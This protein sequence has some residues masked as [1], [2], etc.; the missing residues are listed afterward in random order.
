MAGLGRVLLSQRVSEGVQRHWEPAEGLYR[1]LQPS[2]CST[3]LTEKLEHTHSHSGF[4][5][6]K[7]N[8]AKCFN[9]ASIILNI[10]MCMHSKHTANYITILYFHLNLKY[11]PLISLSLPSFFSALLFQV[12][13][14][15]NSGSA[16]TPT[17]RYSPST[18]LGNT[19]THTH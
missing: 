8:L 10:L 2:P 19:H 4:L 3:H 6:A 9:N 11:V 16:S 15:T 14:T 7:S 18:G 13:C 17:I 5:R 12:T 1:L